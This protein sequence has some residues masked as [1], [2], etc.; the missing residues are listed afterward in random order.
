MVG[1]VCGS[2]FSMFYLRSYISTVRI[3]QGILFVILGV[4]VMSVVFYSTGY[5]DL[6]Q[7]RFLEKSSGGAFE[8]SSSR[9][10]IWELAI[11]RM[12]DTPSSFIVGFGWD[13]YIHMDKLF[14]R[15]THNFYLKQMFNL[16]IIGLSLYLVMFYNIVAKC[17]SAL[18]QAS[19]S[20]RLH[21]MGF[22][23]GIASLG[24]AIFFIDLHAPWIYV[25][26]YV[27]LIMRL[28]VESSKKIEPFSS[29]EIVP[30]RSSSVPRL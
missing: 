8:A 14:P 15:A 7:E 25:W 9:S 22:I 4:L 5:L 16:G 10:A 13:A 2:A 29:N 21:G 18:Q 11:R 19:D 30:T 20:A 27:G 1:I 28:S 24:A 17:R 3:V 12:I 26:A 6:L 23:F